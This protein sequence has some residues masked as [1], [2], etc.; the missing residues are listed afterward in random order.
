VF[1]SNLLLCVTVQHCRFIKLKLTK[2][3]IFESNKLEN[4]LHYFCPLNQRKHER[5]TTTAIFKVLFYFQ[6]ANKANSQK[7]ETVLNF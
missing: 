7:I 2:V 4:A 1:Q 5:Q 6:S 3:Q